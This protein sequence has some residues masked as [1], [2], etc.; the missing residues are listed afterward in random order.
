MNNGWTYYLSFGNSGTGGSIFSDENQGGGET[1]YAY[2]VRCVKEA[3]SG[4]SDVK[5]VNFNVYPNPTAG[6]VY[7]ETENNMNLKLYN[8]Q[9]LLIKETF[10][11]QI[12]LSDY[13]QGLYFLQINNNTVKI[14]KN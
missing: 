7:I 10:D 8:V 2:C 11:K 6:M 12:D 3:S 13:P 14:I 5:S 9:G 1:T 4:V